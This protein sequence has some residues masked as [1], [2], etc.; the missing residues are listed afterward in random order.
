MGRHAGQRTDVTADQVDFA[1]AHDDIGFLE[2]NPAGA[3]RFDLPAL[4]LDA[5]L[6]FLFHEIIVEGL[7]ILCDAHVEV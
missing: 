7:F 6:E 3:Y 1:A 5:G 4:E 2:L